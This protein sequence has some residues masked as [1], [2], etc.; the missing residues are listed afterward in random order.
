MIAKIKYALNPL[1]W[2]ELY[3][4]YL[5]GFAVKNGSNYVAAEEIVRE[6]FFTATNPCDRDLGPC[7]E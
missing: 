4:D 1:L 5:I 7:G 2:S 3:R 6:V